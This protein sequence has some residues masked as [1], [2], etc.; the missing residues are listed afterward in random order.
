MSWIRQPALNTAS[1]QR[2]LF[3]NCIEIKI[4]YIVADLQLYYI[5]LYYYIVTD[6]Q[7][8]DF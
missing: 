1:C 8:P 4:D 5:I 7:F 3:Y 6:L 2:N